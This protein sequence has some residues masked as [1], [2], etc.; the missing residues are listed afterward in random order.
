MVK[1][2]DCIHAQLVNTQ[3]SKVP[4]DGV[5][6]EITNDDG[7]CICLRHNPADP[8]CNRFM[9][10]LFENG[11]SLNPPK[12]IEYGLEKWFPYV[13]TLLRCGVCNEAAVKFARLMKP[14]LLPFIDSRHEQ[15][16]AWLSMFER[17]RTKE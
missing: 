4:I 10:A 15:M 14:R 16:Y 9:V 13:E 8:L 3:S 5:V 12:T 6:L 2:V 7:T 1:S 11:N 17:L